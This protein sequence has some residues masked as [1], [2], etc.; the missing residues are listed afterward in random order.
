MSAI[1]AAILA[2]LAY[3]IAYFTYGR[4]I[5]TKVLKLNP[6][7]RTPAREYEDGQDYVPTNRFVLF[8]HHFAS[9]AGLGPILGPAI[10]VIWGWLPAMLWAV[11]G[12]IFIGAVHDVSA[13]G[14]SLRHQG[15]SIG[16]VTRDVIGPRARLLFLVIVFFILALAMG[17]FALTIATLFSTLR[18]EAAM[19]TFA[20]IGIAA[21]LGYSVRKLRGPVVPLT[22]VALAL[23]VF[24]IW[25]G[26]QQPDLL[27]GIGFQTW[28]FILLTYAFVAS[29]LPVWLLLQ[30]R[31]YLNSYQLYAGLALI[32]VGLLLLSPNFQ[33][34][35]VNSDINLEGS[36]V[37]PPLF[38][39][40]F[41]IVA[42]GA[43]SGFHSLVSSGTTVRQLSTEGHARIIGYGGMLLEGALAVLVI[44]A[45][46]AGFSSEAAWQA[47]YFSFEGARG[48]APKLNAF[49]NGA[50]L[51]IA[52]VGISQAFAANLV[53]VV[54]V[55][56]ALTTLDSATR[57]LRYNVEEIARTVSVKSLANRYTAS[58]IAVA[59]IAFF[60]LMKF[61]DPQTGKEVSAGMVLWAL[62]GTSNQILAVMGLLTVTIFLYK[63]GRPT[64][65]TLVPMLFM[66]C[67]TGSA[68]AIQLH[69]FWTHERYALAVVGTILAALVV[70]LI[71]EGAIAYRTYTVIKKTVLM[72][73]GEPP[74]ASN[75]K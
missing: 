1:L 71:V 15:R 36:G 57:L 59:A 8:G 63:L 26:V 49:V 53:A 12:S 14:L 48:L 30:P 20:L 51:F 72:P 65:Y 35:A 2:F 40:L 23:M 69:D 47:H 61:H 29:V 67:V 34:P 60:A 27:R 7:N 75:P 64:I 68:L 17:V 66:L 24:A 9:I 74:L 45:C 62:F 73:S 41:I 13:L 5:S 52:Q 6:A 39:F 11:F 28:V 54:V 10:A 4:F 21:V 44:I 55:G 18:P 46:T 42:C 50:G 25:F 33:A 3:G 22:I 43:V 58:L 56:F 19:P 31:D 16:D 37:A 32:F 70:W 38:P